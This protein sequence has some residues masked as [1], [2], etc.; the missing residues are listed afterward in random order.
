MAAQAGVWLILSICCICVI[1]DKENACESP[2]GFSPSS[3]CSSYFYCDQL[4]V[5][6]EG[7]CEEGKLWNKEL[8]FCDFAQ[9]VTC[10]KDLFWFFRK[11][12]AFLT[13]GLRL[14]SVAHR[15]TANLLGP[16]SVNITKYKTEEDNSMFETGNTEKMN[17]QKESEEGIDTYD[18]RQLQPRPV[19]KL[20]QE[21][22][23]SGSS[24]YTYHDDTDYEYHDDGFD[25][26]IKEEKKAKQNF[27]EQDKISITNFVNKKV[28]LFE[29]PEETTPAFTISRVFKPL[30]FKPLFLEKK[31]ENLPAVNKDKDPGTFSPSVSIIPTR[32]NIISGSKS[33]SSK[34]SLPWLITKWVPISLLKEN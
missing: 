9:N 27:S 18:Y 5:S 21:E 14:A 4:G 6:R 25:K 12:S 29:Q 20:S 15:V 19:T 26:E 34:A 3:S 1:A 13:A 24:D 8:E 11:G 10:R 32:V 2:S 33:S 7:K 17:E 28:D 16:R 23:G 22:E 30:F 31:I